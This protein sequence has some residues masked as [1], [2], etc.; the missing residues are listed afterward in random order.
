MEKTEIKKLYDEQSLD[1]MRTADA[2]LERGVNRLQELKNFAHKA[3]I[4]R[5]G[6]AHCLAVK[7]EAE[8]V[9]Q[10]LADEFEVYII[11]CKCGQLSKMDLLD[12]DGPGILCNPAQQA[13]YLKENKTE[14]N[15]SMGL[16]VGHDMVFNQKSAAPVSPLLVKDRV[17]RHN[18]MESIQQASKNIE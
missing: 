8:V 6:I 16:C 13:E 1:I 2:A 11:D 7:K 14:L 5:I 18:T 17:N 15:I 12:I 9:K 3:G 4:K 10:F